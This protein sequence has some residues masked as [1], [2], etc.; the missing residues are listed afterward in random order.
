MMNISIV[1]ESSRDMGTLHGEILGVV[2][3]PLARWDYRLISS[4]PST[5]VFER[6]FH[7]WWTFVVSVILFPIGLFSLL[8]K[9]TAMLTMILAERDSG[10][11]VT[12]SGNADKKVATALYRMIL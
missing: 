5:I 2:A 10:S 4:S 6:H 3:P 12:V 11:A 7:P 9:D 8:H 1:K